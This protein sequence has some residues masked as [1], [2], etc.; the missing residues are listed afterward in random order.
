MLRI[1]WLSGTLIL[2]FYICA[3]DSNIAS[4][5][6]SIKAGSKCLATKS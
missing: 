1:F 6:K 5:A 3:T 2:P 4:T